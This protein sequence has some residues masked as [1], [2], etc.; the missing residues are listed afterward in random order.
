MVPDWWTLFTSAV[1][2]LLVL[3]A[4]RW[5]RYHT[6]FARRGLPYAPPLPFVGNM[7]DA[8]I[9]RWSLTD[10]VIVLYNKFQKHRY[11]GVYFFG[12]PLVMVRDPEILRT[13][14]IKDFDH[15]TDHL[16]M[17]NVD[18]EDILLQKML[19]A[20]KGKEWHD[21]RTTLSPAFTTTKIKNM[22]VL[23]TEIGQQMIS[24]LSEKTA[25]H[26]GSSGN[27]VLTL[28]MKEFFTRVTNDV[29]AT[30]A[31]GVRVDSLSEPNNTFYSM[32]RAMSNVKA[33]VAFGYFVSPKLMKLLNIPFFDRRAEQYFRSVVAD[34]IKTR[35]KEGIVRPDVIQL[36]MQARRGELKAEDDEENGTSGGRR[37]KLTEEDVAAQAMFFFFAGFE[38][39]ASVLTFCSYLLAT[40]E[41][42]QRRLQREVDQLMEKSGGQP[43]YEE[44]VGSQYLDMVA[45]EALRMYTP[46][47]A[48]DRKCV[49]PY[50][51]PPTDSCPDGVQLEPGDGVWIPAHALHHDEKYFPDPERFD[52]ERFSPENKH[53]IKPFTYIPFGVGP[54]ICIA[55]RFALLELKVMLIYLLSKFTLHVVDKTPIP[56][57]IKPNSLML[58]IK[59]GAWL[60]ISPRS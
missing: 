36:L 6:H 30:T 24:F 59:G 57:Q 31:F 22:F 21:M 13:I 54:R 29:I 10:H 25:E 32:G 45:S 8:L 46:G 34:T 43:G 60:G 14:T 17:A 19:I 15:F 41:E 37:M 49:K 9:G 40:N 51:L 50:R 2:G 33:L 16:D 28:E 48:S 35:D 1:A 53:R 26:K 4:F 55:Q 18:K 58:S 42:V 5:Y 20:L 39:V 11:A 27:D 12:N 3:A 44:V 7:L 52:P 56:L 47:S 38:T 23:M